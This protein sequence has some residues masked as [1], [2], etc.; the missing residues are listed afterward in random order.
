MSLRIGTLADNPLL[1]KGPHGIGRKERKKGGKEERRKEERKKGRDE[2]KERKERSVCAQ[3][4]QA[5]GFCISLADTMLNLFQEGTKA[6]LFHRYS[7]HPFRST[8]VC[9]IWD[10]ILPSLVLR[11]D[12]ICQG[13][14]TDSQAKF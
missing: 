14:D 11:P 7:A 9:F 12:W 10:L 4:Q 13:L 5:G 6:V 1:K 3:E 8:S 2:E